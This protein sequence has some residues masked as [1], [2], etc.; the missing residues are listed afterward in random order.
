ML[1]LKPKKWGIVRKK[2]LKLT[3]AMENYL[4]SIYMVME[5]MQTVSNSNLVDQLRRVPK[6]ENLGTSLP[7]VSGMLKRMEKEGLIYSNDN[8]EILL[9]KIGNELAESLIRK[10]RI[11]AK[12]L[13]DLLN[14]NLSRVNAE[15]HMLEHAIS[16]ELEGDIIKKLDYPKIDPFG[17]PIPDSGYK[18]PKSLSTIIFSAKE[19]I[20][21]KPS[22][23]DI[24][25]SL[26][27][28]P[29]DRTLS[30]AC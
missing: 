27:R 19:G 17:Q 21:F 22:R 24:S 26:I 4:L 25:P 2:N 15:S 6:T 14:V 13:V 10:H 28:P 1:A 9:T 16:D 8:R 5:R 11:A 30:S 12:M 18:T 7:S 3:Q 20:P 23:V 29:L